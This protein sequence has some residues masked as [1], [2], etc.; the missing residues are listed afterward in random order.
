MRKRLLWALNTAIV[1]GTVAILLLHFSNTSRSSALPQN[2][3]LPRS[4]QA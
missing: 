4:A 1:F 2:V 3:T